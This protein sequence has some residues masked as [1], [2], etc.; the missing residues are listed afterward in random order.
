MTMKWLFPLASLALSC[1]PPTGDWPTLS[2]EQPLDLGITRAGEVV[3]RKA[4]CT[5]LG[6]GKGRA[7][8]VTDIESAAPFSAD[9]DGTSEANAGEQ[10]SILVTYAPTTAGTHTATLVLRLTAGTTTL[11][12]RGTS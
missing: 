11:S 8:L 3:R 5:A 2:C 6:G 7:L 1:V 9:V 4:V 10:L 12:V